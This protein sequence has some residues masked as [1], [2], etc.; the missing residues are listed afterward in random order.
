MTQN[1][2]STALEQAAF[3]DLR[4]MDKESL[5][6]ISKNKDELSTLTFD[7]A[8]EKHLVE[9]G[10]RALF[11]WIRIQQMAKIFDLFMALAED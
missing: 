1:T 10:S 5:D 6:F 7:E 8:V 11:G 9:K 2:R 3:R 4:Y